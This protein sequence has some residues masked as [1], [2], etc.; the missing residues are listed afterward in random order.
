MSEKRYLTEREVAE[1]TRFALPT[2][3]NERHNGRGIPY[4]KV[5]RSVRYEL[6]DVHQYMEAHRI[7]TQRA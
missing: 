4:I 1:I 6:D 7:N 2:L 5:G 3:R